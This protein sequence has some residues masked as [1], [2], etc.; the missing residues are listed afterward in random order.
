ML[1]TRIFGLLVIFGLTACGS[2]PTRPLSAASASAVSGAPQAGSSPNIVHLA[3]GQP[4][5]GATPL[6]IAQDQGL[7]KKYGLNTELTLVPPPSGPKALVSGDIQ[8]HVG[9]GTEILDA[10]AS[11]ANLGF[12]AET[13]QIYPQS[14]YGRPVLQEVSD[15]IGKSVGVAAPGGTTDLALRTLLARDALDVSKVKIVYLG[16][17]N[18]GLAALTNNSIQAA[19]LVPPL[20]LRARQAGMR[21]L[22]DMAP[23]KLHT[24][25]LGLEVRVDWAQQHR[26]VVERFLKGYL[27]GAKEYKANP[28]LAKSTI[29]KWTNVD[30]EAVLDE[31]YS[32][33]APT[34][35]AYPLANEAD[36]RNVMDF[37]TNDKV[38]S[39]K[40]S[41]FYDNSYLQDLGS[42][43]Q[44]L[45]PD[46]IPQA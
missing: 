19:I 4:G 21:L 35:A 8:F 32:T 13:V 10:A 33:G 26:D 41:D 17:N 40:P 6:W 30:D 14:L 25:A 1:G 16:S 23:L 43:V 34:V 7:F 29:R 27:E 42:F 22:V 20:T 38:K 15:L 31:T 3:Y 28:A 9:G 11:G 46:G 39:L 2:A 5:P 12:V 45:W 36:F 37:S 44:G 18:N 24:A